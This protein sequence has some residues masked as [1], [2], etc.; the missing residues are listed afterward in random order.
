MPTLHV[1]LSVCMSLLLNFLSAFFIVSG[2]RH[3]YIEHFFRNSSQPSQCTPSCRSG[4]ALAFLRRSASDHPGS[5][6]PIFKQLFLLVTLSVRTSSTPHC[7]QCTPSWRSGRALQ[8]Q[9]FKLQP[10][11]FRN[12][13]HRVSIFYSVHPYAGGPVKSPPPLPFWQRH[14]IMKIKICK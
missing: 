7:V 13:L 6:P 1:Q 3:D 2:K 12:N 8:S 10:K 11:N 14:I 9:C 4:G 5:D